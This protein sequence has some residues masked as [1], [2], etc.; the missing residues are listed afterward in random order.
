MRLWTPRRRALSAYGLMGILFIGVTLLSQELIRGARIDLTENHLYTLTPGTEHLLSHL[1]EPITLTFYFSQ[2]AASSE[3]AV[4]AYAARV[5]ELL[6]EI[7]ARSNHHITFQEHDPK[8]YSEEEDQANEH[9]LKSAPG[10]HGDPLWFGLHAT[11]STDGQATIDFFRPEREPFLEYDVIRLIHQLAL[12]HRPVIGLITGLPMSAQEATHE[13]TERWTLL[14][15]LAASYEVKT[16]PAT[17]SALP[18]GLAALFVIQPPELSLPL[19][20]A[21]DHYLTHGGALL[22]CIDPDAQMAD[23]T[24]ADNASADAAALLQPFLSAWGV[25]FDPE[26]VVGDWEHALRVGDS[27]TPTR[28]LA[29]MGIGADGFDPD[30]AI[31]GSLSLMNLATPG[32]FVFK[33]S[34]SLRFTPLIRTGLQ[35]G[36]FSHDQW[37]LAQ[38]ADTLAAGFKVTHRR[39]VLAARLDGQLPSAFPARAPDDAS[40]AKAPIDRPAQ[41][42]LVA[43]TDFLADPLWMRAGAPTPEAPLQAWANNGDFIL[44]ALD[45]LTGTHDLMASRARPVLSRPFTRIERLRAQADAQWQRDESAL[46]EQLALTE[47]KLAELQTH[48]SDPLSPGLSAEQAREVADF[49]QKRMQL[50]K[51][52][53][54]TRHDLDARIQQLGSTL[55]ALN[56]WAIPAII[57]LVGL[58]AGGRRRR[59]VHR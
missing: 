15:E 3:P 12:A 30:D 16:I 39:Y 18:E 4:R 51:Q 19:R 10:E 52:L 1:Q 27:P 46:Q 33:P 34:G 26:Q 58:I 55:K 38:S 2:Q 44:N 20:E 40:K 35:A 25:H 59:P 56:V 24:S 6:I 49:Q 17:A 53:R 14:T 9:S 48:R 32:H 21:I 41:V 22:L 43:D 45:D 47:S 13:S 54:A 7:T 37:V 50:R 28:H 57:L 8:P 36:V 5:R 42:I 11:N 29:F 23:S 31:T